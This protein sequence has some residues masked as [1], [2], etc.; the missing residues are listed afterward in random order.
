MKYGEVGFGDLIKHTRG[1][2]SIDMSGGNVTLTEA[3]SKNSVIAAGGHSVPV[4]LVWPL[5]VRRPR[6]V[7]VVNSGSGTLTCKMLG[8]S[9][10]DV[11]AGATAIFAFADSFALIVKLAGT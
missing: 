2:A 8:G 10:V 5:N 4:E 6:M 1:S 11:A 3:E 7:G 9:G